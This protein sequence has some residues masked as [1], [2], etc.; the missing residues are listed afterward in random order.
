MHARPSAGKVQARFDEKRFDHS[1]QPKTG[2][3][4]FVFKSGW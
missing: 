1:A 4:E 3:S 2:D